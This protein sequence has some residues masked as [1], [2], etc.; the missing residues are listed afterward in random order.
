MEDRSRRERR[1]RDLWLRR[2][3]AWD[4]REDTATPKAFIVCL[5]PAKRYGPL[6][7]QA[8]QR[9]LSCQV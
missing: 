7:S 5:S 9:L 6:W 2:E 3:A 1:E 8:S 4:S